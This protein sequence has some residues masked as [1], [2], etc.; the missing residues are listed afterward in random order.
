LPENAWITQIK[1]SRYNKGEAYVIANNYRNGDFGVY[2]FKTA[3]YGTTWSHLVN[4]K[5]VKGYALCLLQDPVEKN[6]FFVGTEQGLWISV[7]GANSFEQ[8]KNGYPSV[9]TY[10]LALQEREA[11]LAIATF[12]R[13]LW[14]LDNIRP[15]R[16][17]AKNNGMVNKKLM[18][19]EPATATKVSIRNAPGY[20]WSSWGLYEGDNRTFNGQIPFYI[21]PLDTNK[22]KTDTVDV[23]IFNA[24]NVQIRN[25]KW[26]VDTG[27][28]K[29]S[30]NLD[31]KGFRFP[32][33][34]KPKPNDREPGGYQVAPGKYK[35]VLQYG[36]FKDSTTIT[37]LQDKRLGKERDEIEA[38]Q[39]KELD[40]LRTETEKLTEAFDRL[41]DAEDVVNKINMQWKD[42]EGKEADSIR[43]AGKQVLDK[44]KNIRQYVNG[45]PQEKQGY[46][47]PYQNTVMS[48][49]GAARGE[50]SGKPTLGETHGAA[51][52]K[53][54]QE[55]I[56]LAL[57]KTNNFFSTTYK[58]YQ[59]TIEANKPP[60][61]KEYK[62]L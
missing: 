2:I 60:L 39:I 27:Y 50:L 43:K 42:I 26:K 62:P 11:D 12:G 56:R 45:I 59:K 6:L 40:G 55:A 46:G 32:G 38:K 24:S 10:D 15:L 25:L 53:I 28:N 61:F 49:L 22:V 44:I 34:P 3:D 18:A 23:K 30:W 33:S 58:D 41:Q 29:G 20:E 4:D 52:L 51:L 54:A 16:A 19:F 13:A 21:N 47:R 37:V 31:S 57:D 17:L 35:V 8:F 9:S 14:V 1:A 7:D 5:K 36:R 48:K